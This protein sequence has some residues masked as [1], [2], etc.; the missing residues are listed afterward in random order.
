MFE[1][2]KKRSTKFNDSMR[3]VL[4]KFDVNSK[5]RKVR[6]P[7]IAPHTTP[8]DDFRRNFFIR[9]FVFRR[10][11]AY[12]FWCSLFCFLCMWR[13]KMLSVSWTIAMQLHN[14]VVAR[15]RKTHQLLIKIPFPFSPVIKH[16]WW[17]L[18]WGCVDSFFLLEFP[19]STDEPS[20][21]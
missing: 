3:F 18:G 19:T 15:D 6:Y 4:E 10:F 1:Q 14:F 17:D 13:P 2:L 11:S 8:R 5:T 16:Y 21:S 7:C 20:V 12:K 9:F